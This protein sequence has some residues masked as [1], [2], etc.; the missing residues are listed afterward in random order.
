MIWSWVNFKNASYCSDNRSL[1]TWSYSSLSFSSLSF[2]KRSHKITTCFTVSPGWSFVLREGD[3]LPDWGG[4]IDPALGG[5]WSPS[6]ILVCGLDHEKLDDEVEANMLW[7][8]SVLEFGGEGGP[9]IS[10]LLLCSRRHSS[11]TLRASSSR[12]NFGVASRK[13][14]GAA[15]GGVETA[16][17]PHR[18]LFGE[19]TD[20]CSCW[21]LEVSRSKLW[22]LFRA[23]QAIPVEK[24]V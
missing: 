20:C 3:E 2:H 5:D 10:F 21:G 12:S 1:R 14:D 7:M 6:C 11:C 24:N 19:A 16:K 8:F 13:A 17:A 4:D 15:Q 23:A 9:A 22:G 18:L